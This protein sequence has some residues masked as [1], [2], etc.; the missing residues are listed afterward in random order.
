MRVAFRDA[1]IARVNGV[2]GNQVQLNVRF[3]GQ[4]L[5]AVRSD[6]SPGGQNH[7]VYVSPPGVWQGTAADASA[8]GTLRIVRTGTTV[9]GYV[10]GNLVHS[11]TYNGGDVTRLW[12]ALQTARRTPPP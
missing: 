10:N 3:G 2:P 9:S 1:S 5:A 4:F 12:L 7:H 6:E 8:A 11:A